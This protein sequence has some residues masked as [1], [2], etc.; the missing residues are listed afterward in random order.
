MITCSVK[1]EDREEEFFCSFIYA[2]NFVEERKELWNDLRD[3]HNSPIIRKK[4]WICIGDYNEILDG[5][6][7]SEFTNSP[8][9]PLGM[10][11][12]QEPVR[13]CSF[14]NMAFHGHYLRGVTSWVRV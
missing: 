10:R 1:L 13:T 8:V 6:E 12:F 11:D 9:I 2:S 14:E 7:H 3:H 4:P 5:E